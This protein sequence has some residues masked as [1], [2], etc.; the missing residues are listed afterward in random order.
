MKRK[1]SFFVVTLGCPKNEVESDVIRAKL[2][3]KFKETLNINQADYI[4]VNTCAFVK[5]A[6]TQSDEVINELLNSK[7]KNQNIVVTGCYIG[8]SSEQLENKF[9]GNI[10]I[11]QIPELHTLISD[12]QKPDNAEIIY[13]TNYENANFAYI[14]ISDGCNKKC[15]YCTIPK[16]KG[17]YASRNI[18]SILLETETLLKSGIKEI[19]LVSQDTCY[20]GIDTGIR[21]GLIELLKKITLFNYDYRIRLMYLNPDGITRGLLKIIS[22][23]EK[24]CNY[25]DMPVQHTETEILKAMR[26]PFTRTK[27]FE[28]VNFIRKYNPDISIRSVVITGYPGE[29]DRIFRNML[30]AL[31]ILKFDKLGCF[32]YSDEP[33]AYSFTLKN[34]VA[35]N[36][37]TKRYNQIMAQQQ[38]ISALLNSH[39]TGLIQKVIIDGYDSE[40][41]LF[42]ARNEYNAPEID[43]YVLFKTKKNIDFKK[44]YNIKIQKST[45]YDLLGELVL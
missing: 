22:D 33:D 9:G 5:S 29:T 17:K 18:D 28:L 3:G 6:V 4:I 44:F 43:G 16:I 21:N 27:I 13:R 36:I 38:K 25:L 41:K 15:G 12:N 45:E 8:R 37:K 14:K 35:A 19:I 26:R 11:K 32:E 23:N 7:K 10:I 42:L 39:K 30:E 40:N 2:S 31:K 34:K 24:I 1:L 20:Y